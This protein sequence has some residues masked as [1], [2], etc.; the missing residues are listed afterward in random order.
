M[1]MRFFTVMISVCLA[2][3]AGCT[4]LVAIGADP[5][6]DDSVLLAAEGHGLAAAHTSQLE[7]ALALAA[8]RER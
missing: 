3:L 4:D 6:T 8:R 2:L 1:K 7:R 5:D